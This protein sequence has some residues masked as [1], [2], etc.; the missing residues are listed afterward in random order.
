[1]SNLKLTIIDNRS[2]KQSTIK[3]IFAVNDNVLHKE[4]KIK[5]KIVHM[6]ESRAA[7][8]WEDGSRER[9]SIDSLTSELEYT[10]DTQ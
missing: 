2:I 10:D 9:F 8:L 1:M 6:G 5:G 7:V 4:E 3:H